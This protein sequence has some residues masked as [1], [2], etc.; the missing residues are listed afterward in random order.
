MATATQQ[1]IPTGSWKIDPIHSSVSF[2]VQHMG[3]S[4]FSAGFG[5]VDAALTVGD[6]G[7]RLSGAAKVESIAIDEPQ[8]RGH[9]LSPE[10]FD[11]ERHSEIRFESDGIRIGDG[12]ELTLNGELTIRDA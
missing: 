2:S 9:L 1:Q 8:L 4:V 7:A 3:L 6:D 12:G 11:T 5:E 10:F